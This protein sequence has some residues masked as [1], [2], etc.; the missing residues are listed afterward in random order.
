MKIYCENI[1][2]QHEELLNRAKFGY[3]TNF[4]QLSGLCLEYLQ[5]SITK[6]QNR[7]SYLSPPLSY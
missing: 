1:Y 7:N 6:F 3:F 5:E 2:L 4:R